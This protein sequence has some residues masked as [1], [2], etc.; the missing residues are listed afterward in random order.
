AIEACLRMKGKAV[1]VGSISSLGTR[2][3]VGLEA[4]SCAPGDTLAVGQAESDKKENV[5]K[6]L[7]AVSG[8]VRRKLGESL[9]SLKK[10]DFP[11]DTTTKSIE[12][13]RAFGMGQKAL[14]DSGEGEAIPFFRHAI[15]LDHDFALAYAVLGRAY[16]NVGEDGD[17]M[18]N[19]TK[20][21]QLRAKLSERERYQITTLY[22]E[23]V[24][25]DL[26]QAKATGELWV[27]T[28]PQDGYAREK[29]AT[30]YADLGD[31]EQAHR[32]VQEALRMDPDSTTNV[33]NSVLAAAMLNRLDEAIQIME[34]AR[35]R[36]LDGVAVR[37]SMYSLAFL[38]GDSVGMKRQVAWAMGKANAEDLLLSQESDTEAYYGRLRKA[39][40]LSKRAAGAAK[41]DEAQET[42]AICEIVSAL[43]EI[44]TG[45]ASSTVK[46]VRWALSLA[47]TR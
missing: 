41:R 4:L 25:G 38:S 44:E 20:A 45:D 31:I 6:A 17:A 26:D 37:Q 33:F 12:A 16:E 19:F 5:L 13:L 9:P 21:F 47:P 42:A 40:E 18:R 24:T 36:G 30:V 29:L 7:D 14:R 11:V 46:S 22:H 43:R 1:L 23:T 3:V 8:Q 15:E 34:T 2:Y 39:R 28:Y 10:Y 27:Q 35:A 32:N